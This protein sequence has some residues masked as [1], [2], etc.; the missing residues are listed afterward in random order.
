MEPAPKQMYTQVSKMNSSFTL[1][2]LKLKIH[3]ADTE[4]QACD[5]IIML[6]LPK[7]SGG[8]VNTSHYCP[9]ALDSGMKDIHMHAY[10]LPYFKY[11]LS[12]FMAGPLLNFHFGNTSPP[13]LRNYY[14]LKSMFSL[15]YTRPK[16]GVP[17]G[18]S[19]QTPT[20]LYTLTSPTLQPA[21]PA[22]PSWRF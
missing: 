4:L 12:S 6:L 9:N 14:L 2:P 15:C 5:V 18:C 10:T 11:A 16:Y 3:I 17:W 20:W 21:L 22:S 1:S 19:F 7:L 8:C 13:I